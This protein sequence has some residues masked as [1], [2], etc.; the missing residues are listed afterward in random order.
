MPVDIEMII[1]KI[2]LYFKSYTVRV[3]TLKNFCGFLES[4][5]SMILGYSQTRWLALLPAIERVLQMFL[6]LKAYFQSQEKCPKLILKF[7]ENPMAEAWLHFIN[8]QALIFH[9]A[10]ATIEN[11][12]AS[13]FDVITLTDAIKA[14]LLS[15]I[16]DNYIPI[17]V[18]KSLEKLEEN[19]DVSQREIIK[20]QQAIVSFYQTALTYLEKW[21]KKVFQEMETY[22][23][24][25][26]KEIPSWN[27]IQTALLLINKMTTNYKLLETDTYEEYVYLKQYITEEKI[28]DWSK[29]K[30]CPVQRWIE[31]S[32]HFNKNQIPCL[33]IL[34]LPEFFF[35]FPGTNAATER[36][37]SIMNNFWT[38]DK[39]QLKVD[40][41]KGMLISKINFDLSCTDFYKKIKNE[42]EVL[43]NIHSSQ[44]YMAKS[45][46]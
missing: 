37:F 17:N 5:F 3:E 30:K 2:Y 41:L 45:L 39:T 34:K 36:V 44:K 43:K 15:K 16:E 11:Q 24:I 9:K 42:K 28:M 31:I 8:T 10:I 4:D 12:T 27:Q 46:N 7:F 29:N 26:L 35:C 40:T 21:T 20:F 19:G 1:S 18:Q 38:S 23:W 33:N 22:S 6:P 13:V 25:I 32:A 14:S